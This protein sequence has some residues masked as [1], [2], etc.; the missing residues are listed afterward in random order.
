VILALAASAFIMAFVSRFAWPPLMPAV[1]P[2][3]N[4][5]RAE[6]LAYMSAFYLGYIITQIPGGVLADRFGPRLVL[7]TALLFQGLGTFC[8]GLTDSYQAGFVLRILCGLGGGCVYSS[9]FKA[10]ATWFSPAGRGLAIAVL[11]SAP[12]VG[13]AVPNFALP[14]LE[15]G[16][17]WQGAFQ[18][19]GVAVIGLAV[20]ILFFFK[21]VPT[22]SGPRR[23]FVVGLKYVLGSRNLILIS[24]VGF[25]GLW[26]Q[27]GFGSVG[28][29]YLVSA[30]GLNL[31]NAGW[32]MVLYG[33]AGLAMSLA[34]GYL[35]GR[36][37]G[38]KKGLTVA[39]FMLLAV[40]CFSFG[41]LG[42]MGAVL[43]GTCLIGMAVSFAN[44]IQSVLIADFTPPEWMATAGGVTNAIFQVGALLS[45]A[46]IG[47][48]L[49]ISGDFGPTWPLLGAGALVGAVLASRLQIKAE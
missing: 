49:V 33:L 24:L 35:T 40:F 30:F 38:N 31:K 11:M 6:G 34:A 7:A 1:M 19:V 26:V 13:V 4:I 44:V 28:N 36:W 43:A 21:E 22:A 14:A 17:G 41:Q 12:T 48:A 3:M 46:I 37:P 45:P 5:S 23:S 9:C 27:I 20:L 47:R 32:V 2:V 8:L 42:S 29:D 18:A 16:L 15:A 10:V 39:C 25:C